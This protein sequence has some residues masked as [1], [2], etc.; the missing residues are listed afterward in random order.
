MF[1]KNSKWY[2]GAL[3]LVGVV[4]GVALVSAGTSV[5][6]WSGANEFCGTFCHSMDDAYAS[7]K[8]GQHFKTNS[9]FTA[10]CVDCHLK[11]K[12]EPHISQAQVV[13]MLWHKAMSGS[14]SLWGEIRG[15]LD[16]PEKQIE[17]RKELGEKYAAWLRETNFQSCRGC[18]NLANFKDNPNK[19]MVP[20]MHKAMADTPKTD[21]LA[22]HKEV[23]HKYE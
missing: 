16:T 14:S 20:M 18:H 12:S 9:G 4:V 22:C 2:A 6:H 19:P 13:G 3:V 15:T 10:Q 21:C 1:N 17:K 23:G 8:K 7:Y 5:V 11:Y